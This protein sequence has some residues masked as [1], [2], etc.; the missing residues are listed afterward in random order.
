MGAAMPAT[1]CAPLEKLNALR[2]PGEMI[3]EKKFRIR[4][5]QSG[6]GLE[7]LIGGADRSISRG[8]ARHEGRVVAAL[9]VL[10]LL[11][12]AIVQRACRLSRPR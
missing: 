11:S 8:D 12:L 1:S 6:G 9:V 7:V 4:A 2:T 5:G 10:S 3:A